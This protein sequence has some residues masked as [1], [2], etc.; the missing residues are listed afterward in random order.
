M[1]CEN[2]PSSGECKPENED[3]LECVVEWEP[4][5]GAD[6]TLKDGQEREDNPVLEQR[7]QFNLHCRA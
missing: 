3:K 5:D 2:L 4:V 1:E 7:R 6:C